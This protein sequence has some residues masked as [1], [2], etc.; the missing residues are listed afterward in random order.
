MS[1]AG[2]A[3]APADLLIRGGRVIEVEG[4]RAQDVL[5]QAGAIVAVGP[6]LS[7]PPGAPVL[8]AQGRWVLPGLVDP[9]VHFR[10]PGLPHKEDLFSGSL[11]AVAGGVTTFMEMPNTRPATTS[12]AALADKLARADGRSWADHAFFLGATQENADELGAWEQSPG[13]AGV[14]VF[15][16]SSTGD[17]LVPDDATLER[18]LRSG[19]RRVAVHSEDEPRLRE[20][21]A[22]LAPDTP[23]ARHPEVRDVEAALRA[24][25]RLLDLV[26]RTRRPVHVL[27]LST[28]EEVALLRERDLGELVTAEVT[29]NHLFLAAPECYERYGALAQMNPPVRE[30]RHAE[31][32]RQALKDGVIACIGSDHAPHSLAEKA[33]PYPAS[34]S[35]IPGVQTILG[36]LLTAVRA[37]W[38][39]LEDVPRVSARGPCEVYGIAR[40]GRIAPGHDGDLVLV[41]PQERGPL[42][43]EW[44][45][46]RAGYS[47]YVGTHLAG[48]PVTTVLRGRVVYAQHAPVGAPQGRPLTFA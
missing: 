10:E 46:S 8:E 45:R 40:K 5:I 14:K 33:Q 3:P 27:H 20:R 34:P 15:M 28:A 43:L 4:A 25:R 2:P 35:G 37:G 44:L 36:L 7:A 19:T 29:P 47:P 24:T 12:P 22:A 13:C 11:A 39:A 42:P 32:L 30:R 16:G 17:L 21:Y 6:A 48:W 26:E 31:A 1:Q 18:V 9:Q 41:D 38:L 23:V